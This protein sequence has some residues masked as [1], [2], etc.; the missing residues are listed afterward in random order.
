MFRIFA[1]KPVKKTGTYIKFGFVVM[2]H[3]YYCCPRCGGTLN[4]GPGYQPNYCDKCG[5]KVD[6]RETVWTEEKELRTLPAIR[7]DEV[8]E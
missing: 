2:E 8:Y 4:A 1:R 3:E 6:F 5:Q 7:G